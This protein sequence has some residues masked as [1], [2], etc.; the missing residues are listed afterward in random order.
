MNAPF[1]VNPPAASRRRP[2]FT[3]AEMLIVIGIIALLAAILVPTVSGVR[4]TAKRTQSQARLAAIAA[5]CHNYYNDFKAYP[6]P[7]RNDQV[8]GGNPPKPTAGVKIT[9]L[10]RDGSP[11]NF[12]GGENVTPNLVT[13]SENLVL[14]L[15]GGLTANLKQ[16][17]STADLQSFKYERSAVGAGPQ[18]LTAVPEQRKSYSAYLSQPDWLYGSASSRAASDLKKGGAGSAPGKDYACTGIPEFVDADG[19]P[20]LYLRARAGAPVMSPVGGNPAQAGVSANNDLQYNYTH[21][22]PYAGNSTGNGIGDFKKQ[23]KDGTGKAVYQGSQLVYD[24]YTPADFV[25]YLKSPN[26]DASPTIKNP[27]QPRGKDAFILISAGTDGFYGTEDDIIH[28][29]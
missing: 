17:G 13:Q 23:K 26:S 8:V 7:L 3:L 29:Q 20:I 21:L 27:S 12:E 15:M 9:I 25:N 18:S 2:A 11:F 16:S 28:P 24:P 6:G 5:A 10:R 4:K 14:G 1:R 19:I 22:Q